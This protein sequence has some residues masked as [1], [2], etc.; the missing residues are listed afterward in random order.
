MDAWDRRPSYPHSS[1]PQPTA[2]A[3]E[4]E[5]AAYMKALCEVFAYG[6]YVQGFYNA[7]PHPGQC[8]SVG[9]SVWGMYVLRIV[10]PH[11]GK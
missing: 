2:F 6:C 9:W 5:K 10:Y 7:D 8:V 11:P 3:S 1:T 4:E